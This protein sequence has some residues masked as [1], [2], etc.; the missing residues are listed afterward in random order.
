MIDRDAWDDYCKQRDEL[1][2]DFHS[3]YGTATSEAEKEAAWTDQL[4]K[5]KAL[6]E[7]FGVTWPPAEQQASE[8]RVSVF[9]EADDPDGDIGLSHW[10]LTVA[11]RGRDLWAVLHHSYC[12]N[13][14][15]GWDYEMR[16]SAR[17][18]DWLGEHRFHLNE[19]LELARK[20]AP[21]VSVN[22][23]TAAEIKIE[24]FMKGK[25]E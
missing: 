14:Q 10:A 23:H 20:A 9:T 11:W 18:D 3:L 2:A 21:D 16:P 6:R 24:L 7:K 5:L 12:L 13:K 17:E 22:G 1:R 19:A 25:I 8:Y 4:A 15:G